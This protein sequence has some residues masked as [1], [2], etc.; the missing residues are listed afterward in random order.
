MITAFPKAG[1]VRFIPHFEEPRLDFLLPISLL[2]VPDKSG[3]EALPALRVRMGGVAVPVED[4]D[5]RSRERFRR[6]AEFDE[7]LDVPGEQIIVEPIDARPV[8]DRFAVLNAHGLQNIVKDGVKT[9][10]AKTEFIHSQLQLRLAVFTN[11]GAR[12][13]RSHTEI[14]EAI[15]RPAGLL[16]IRHDQPRRNL[17]SMDRSC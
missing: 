14:E 9:N 8:V 11:Q 6:K 7:W 16:H 17:L 4:A 2:D 13:I 1:E 10:V 5:F 15:H 3:Y 12:I